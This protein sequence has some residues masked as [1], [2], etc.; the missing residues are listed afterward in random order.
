MAQSGDE[1]ALLEEVVA[2]LREEQSYRPSAANLEVVVRLTSSV[3]PTNLDLWERSLR[4]A[5]WGIQRPGGRYRRQ[6][7]GFVSWFDL[8]NGS[9]YARESALRTFREGAPN[10]FFF[11]LTLRRLN[12]WVP[13]VRA[14]AREGLDRLVEA[15]NPDHVV[16]ALWVVLP[17]AQNWGRMEL[18]DRACLYSIAAVPA[19]A[20]SLHRQLLAA[21]SGPAA[22][23][24]A[25]A[26]RCEALSFDLES[27]A[28][29]A[30]QP[31][32]RAKAYRSLL[33]RRLTWVAH[34][35]WVWTDFAY[36]K[37]RYEPVIGERSVEP[38]TDALALISGAAS[39]P[40]VH[41]RRVA[42]DALIAKMDSLDEVGLA[43]V[44]DLARD[45]S[46]SVAERAKFVI[47]SLKEQ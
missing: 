3:Q 38:S 2:F 44:T 40:S 21:T 25:Q 4:S 1:K 34:R 30:I 45:S 16:A 14:A 23:V 24:L 10:G 31:S 6:S 20:S 5:L 11:A 8:C 15:T 39:D 46:S 22:I 35:K 9:G 43:L 26:A 27:L 28:Q 7:D 18:E 29:H 36:C 12:D 37:G 33:E 42:A 19:V 41:V 17:N 13:Q 32:V 47:E